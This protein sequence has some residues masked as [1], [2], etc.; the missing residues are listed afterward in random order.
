V[1]D[2]RAGAPVGLEQVLTEGQAVGLAVHAKEDS[3]CLTHCPC[4]TRLISA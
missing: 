1:S 3:A 2:A 4:A